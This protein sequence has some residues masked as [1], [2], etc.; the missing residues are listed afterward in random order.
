MTIDSRAAP[1]GKPHAAGHTATAS[2]G[3]SRRFLPSWISRSVAATAASSSRSPLTSPTLTTTERAACSSGN[4][5]APA[6]ENKCVSTWEVLHCKRSACF[7]VSAIR[8]IVLT[9]EVSPL[10][11][12]VPFVVAVRSHTTHKKVEVE[13]RDRLLLRVLVRVLVL[14]LVLVPVLV[15]AICLYIPPPLFF[16]FVCERTATRTAQ[17]NPRGKPRE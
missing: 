5:G 15:L 11:F 2:S 9:P 17:Q 4:P 8:R 10:G 16:T 3:V 13:C 1:T 7:L 12:A 6:N 14:V